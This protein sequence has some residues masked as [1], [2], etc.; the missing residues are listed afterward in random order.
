[1]KPNHKCANSKCTTGEDGGR[2]LYY[3]CD[4][5]DRT[6]SWR[7][8]CCSIEC[9]EQYTRDTNAQVTYPQRI[10]KTQ[11]EVKE[12]LENTSIEESIEKTKEELKDYKEELNE[13]GISKTI[14]II[15]EEIDNKKSRK[16]KRK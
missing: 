3:A 14:D 9:Y 13:Y 6:A 7:S 2:K 11:K 10:D 8:I 12:F 1:M 5:C 4:Y 15:N 16:S